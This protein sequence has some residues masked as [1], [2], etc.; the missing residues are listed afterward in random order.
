MSWLWAGFIFA[1]TWWMVLF[2]VLPFGVKT[3][4]APGYGHDPGAPEKPMIKQKL[5]I[6]TLLAIIITGIIVYLIRIKF[7]SFTS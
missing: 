1:L 7:V 5:L 2:A 3:P 6:T 4:D